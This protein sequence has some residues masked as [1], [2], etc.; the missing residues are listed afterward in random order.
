MG[1]VVHISGA[2]S[3]I[4][5]SASD[6][7]GSA[8]VGLGDID[9]DGHPD[10]AVGAEGHNRA[11]GAV[12]VMTLGPSATVLTSTV[13]SPSSTESHGFDADLASF[14]YFG[15]AITVLGDLDG[16]GCAELAVGARGRAGAA[17]SASGAGGQDAGAVYILF[18]QARADG[19][20][21]CLTGGS[22]VVRRYQILT[23]P[24]L[25]RYDEF[26]SSVAG[27]GDINGDAIPD[28]IV[29]APGL[30][31][32]SDMGKVYLISLNA[33][34]QELESSVLQSSTYST[35]GMYGTSGG[36]FGAAVAVPLSGA[37]STS[38]RRLTVEAG[39]TSMRIVL[40][41]GAPGNGSIPGCV[42][43]LVLESELGGS[44]PAVGSY[45][46]LE[47]PQSS[48][49]YGS[50]LAYSG[51]YDANG[52]A[53][54][55]VGA[56]GLSY[57]DSGEIM[58]HYMGSGG[59]SV[60]KT[61]TIRPCQEAMSSVCTNTT[62]FG[63]A[64]ASLGALNS[65]DIVS[66]LVIGSANDYPENAMGAVAVIFLAANLQP[67]S[68]PAGPPTRPPASP[69]DVQLGDLAALS[70]NDGS[71]VDG[72]AIGAWAAVPILVFFAVV[73]SWY[74]F[75]NRGHAVKS[76]KHYLLKPSDAAFSAIQ[77]GRI[78]SS[79]RLEPRGSH[80]GKR[81]RSV[82]AAEPN[83]A[84]ASKRA[85]PHE[86]LDLAPMLDPDVLLNVCYAPNVPRNGSDLWLNA[87][88]STGPTAPSLGEARIVDLSDATE[89]LLRGEHQQISAS[90]FIPGYARN[91]PGKR[92]GPLVRPKGHDGSATSLSSVV[93]E[94]RC[95]AAWGHD[96]DSQSS[97]R[98]VEE[99]HAIQS[100]EA[101]QQPGVPRGPG[102]Q[103]S[104]PNPR[105]GSGF[106]LRI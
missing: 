17:N 101:Q 88:Q 80:G 48:F 13:I 55:V 86:R 73:F 63:R 35:A 32:S 84:M 58:I 39:T 47:S 60:Y 59:A 83:G 43:V 4:G 10:M 90:N 78:S 41:V 54:L 65:D 30:A 69:G 33:L 106:M 76:L 75:Q 8:V 28:L 6:Q 5:I 85:P 20:L 66:D 15:S 89:A 51:D 98:I 57:G 102:L 103:P 23:P 77:Q 104:L 27:P 93:E 95:A 100:V 62:N 105:E 50:A 26:G 21:G 19:F 46:T 45:V 94:P 24:G 12:H 92:H 37:G 9:G 96:A 42:H 16:D 40:A 67:P 82:R 3:K 74:Y 38:G 53:E 1:S 56:P 91:V 25:E 68:P 44:M 49:A 34:G 71:L 31:H 81:A 29:G 61:V 36:R 18:L 11:T 70:A 72:A 52:A 97:T 7:F 22:L 14:S 87:V 2:E 99:V 79:L 64:I